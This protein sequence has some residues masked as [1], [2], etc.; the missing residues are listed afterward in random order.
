LRAL[1]CAT[2]KVTWLRWLLTDFGIAL[3]S[4]TLV[5]C[6][7]TGAISIAQDSMKHE[8]T[9]HIGVDCFYVQYGIQEKIVDLQYIC[10]RGFSLQTY[11]TRFTLELIIVFFF[12]TQCG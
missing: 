4:S 10:P 8:L 5:H 1:T 9:K 7:N 2:A 3:S 11:L 12:Q 6:D